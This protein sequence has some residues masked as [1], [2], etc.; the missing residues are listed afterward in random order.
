MIVDLANDDPQQCV[1]VPAQCQP[2]PVPRKVPEAGAAS[3]SPVT[4]ELP[5]W[6]WGSALANPGIIRR[7]AKLHSALTVQMQKKFLIPRQRI[8]WMI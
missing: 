8:L 6:V 2:N 4:T 7:V 1:D 5:G 3:T